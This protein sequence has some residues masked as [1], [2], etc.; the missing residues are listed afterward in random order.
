MIASL[1]F[2]DGSVS[3]RLSSRSIDYDAIAYR[4]G[5]VLTEDAGDPGGAGILMIPKLQDGR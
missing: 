1:S 4:T 3:R 2:N 5:S